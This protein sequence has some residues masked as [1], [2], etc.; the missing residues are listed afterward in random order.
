MDT[1]L[2][3]HV[4][5]AFAVT[6]RAERVNYGSCS[7]HLA[8]HSGVAEIHQ[9][10]L[11]GWNWGWWALCTYVPQVDDTHAFHIYNHLK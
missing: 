2:Q 3:T 11:S 1:R 7:V 6:S 9:K 10:H 5:V 4:D 8:S